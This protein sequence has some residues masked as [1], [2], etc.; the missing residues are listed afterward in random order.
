LLSRTRPPAFSCFSLFRLIDARA[1]L[2]KFTQDV[3][4]QVFF[5]FPSTKWIN[6]LKLILFGDKYEQHKAVSPQA[7][8]LASAVKSTGATDEPVKRRR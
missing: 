1:R 8:S 7:K 4:I 5:W 2:E 6:F 3:Q